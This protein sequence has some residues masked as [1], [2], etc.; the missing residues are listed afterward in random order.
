MED[1]FFN[2]DY[3]PNEDSI[4]FIRFLDTETPQVL[5]IHKVDHSSTVRVFDYHQTNKNWQVVFEDTVHHDVDGIDNLQI[6]GSA[7]LIEKSKKEQA[8]IGLQ[9][10][11][12]ASL[13]FYIL[14]TRGNEFK[15]FVDHMNTPLNESSIRIS[16]T[17]AILSSENKISQR[18]KLNKDGDVEFRFGSYAFDF[19]TTQTTRPNM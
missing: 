12:S 4:S 16:G 3:T 15:K 9:S 2:G 5:T 14:G 11:S 13:R 19:P 7:P 1:L 6:F 10:E 8:I 17:E 18:F